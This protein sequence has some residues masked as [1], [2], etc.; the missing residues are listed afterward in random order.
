PS[1]MGGEDFGQ[2]LRASPD[3]IKSLIFWVGGVPQEEFAR[4]QKGEIELPSLH[5]PFWAPDAEAV[6]STAAEAMAAATLD[7]MRASGG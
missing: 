2:F 3:D 1:V 6:I 5:S 4:A 7:L